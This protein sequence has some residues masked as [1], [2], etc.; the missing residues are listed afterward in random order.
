MHT[1]LGLRGG[2][3][4]DVRAN[5]AFGATIGAHFESA[6]FGQE[7]SGERLYKGLGFDFGLTYRFQYR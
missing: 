4:V 3:G 7:K 1:G 2:V 6:S 5:D